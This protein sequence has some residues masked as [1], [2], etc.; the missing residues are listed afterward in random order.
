MLRI[1]P[2]HLS[3]LALLLR[4]EGFRTTPWQWHKLGQ[5]F[6]L[7]RNVEKRLR[8]HVRGFASGL[9]ESEIEPA[10]RYVEHHTRPPG[11]AD[12]YTAGLLRRAGIPYSPMSAS[13]RTI[14]YRAES[15]LTD[16]RPIAATAVA[17]ALLLLS[18]RRASTQN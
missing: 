8:L 9:V 14:Q 12:G 18:S 2:I 10:P 3:V 17:A 6:G 11:N 15:R 7:V 13:R 1:D 5:V 16:W 4:A